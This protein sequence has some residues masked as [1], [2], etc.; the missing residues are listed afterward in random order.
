MSEKKIIAIIGGG[1]C[2]SMTAVNMLNQDKKNYKILLIE[3]NNL[4]ARGLAYGVPD[5]NLLLNVPASNMSAIANKPDDFLNYCISLNSSYNKN[6]FVQRIIY[7]D[8]LEKTLNFAIKNNQ[9]SIEIIKAEVIAIHNNKNNF[10]IEFKNG[11]KQIVEKVVLALGHFEKELRTDVD[12]KFLVKPWDFFEISKIKKE[13]SVVI[14][15]T[16]H[17]AIDILFKLTADNNQ[18]KVIMFSRHGLLPHSHIF[19]KHPIQLETNLNFLKNINP[20]ILS[21]FHALRAEIKKCKLNN[22]DWRD[23]L[24]ELRSHTANIFQLL[25]DQ[26]KS[27]FIKKILPYWSIHRHRLA[28][29]AYSKLVQLIHSGQVK[30]FAGTLDELKVVNNM[31]KFKIRKNEDMNEFTADILI[32]CSGP[33]YDIDKISHPLIKQLY[34]SDQ[35]QPDSLKLGIKIDDNYHPINSKGQSNNNLFYVG[36]M[37]MA[38]YWEAIAV[39]E[40]SQHV[41]KVANRVVK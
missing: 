28:P 20:T 5:N 24:T 11:T 31:L 39:P 2:G 4:L 40:L 41:Y 37:L 22:I 8:Y 19:N 26:E 17:T 25:P 15:G 29:E 35:I 34:Q 38:K 1:Y 12:K 27:K 13:K 6:S 30:V 32:D 18:R 33:N 3:K 23:V 7:G 14:M 10:I 9:N 16:G 21:Y 36:P